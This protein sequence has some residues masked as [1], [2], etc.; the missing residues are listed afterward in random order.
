VVV[1]A[2]E[3]A[4]ESLASGRPIKEALLEVTKPRTKESCTEAGL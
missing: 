4:E 3:E 2:I 1:T